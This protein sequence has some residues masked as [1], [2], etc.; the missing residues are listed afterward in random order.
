VSF[1]G[2]HAVIADNF[3]MKVGDGYWL[4][5]H[6]NMISRTMLIQYATEE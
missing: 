5:F 1:D 4:V 2:L 6:R 3:Q